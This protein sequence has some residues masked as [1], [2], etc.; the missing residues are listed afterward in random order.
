MID[1]PSTEMISARVDEIVVEGRH[2]VDLGDLS[3]LASSIDELGLL[4]PITVTPDLRLIAGHRRLEACR[5]LDRPII[6]ACVV[7]DLDT[8]QLRLMAERDENV[9]RME[10]RPSEAAS[11]GLALEE[12][13]RPKAAGRKGAR[14]DLQP[15]ANF[16]PG[17]D[18][19]KVND[20]VGPAVG[21]SHETYRKAKNVLRAGRDGEDVDGSPLPE[22]VAKAARDA[23]AQM[24]ATGKVSPAYEKLAAAKAEQSRKSDPPS[25]NSRQAVAEKAERA[26]QLAASGHTSRQIA[27]DL[28]ITAK[29]VQ[30]L[31]KRHGIDIPADAI[32]GRIRIVDTRRVVSETVLELEA[33][34]MSLAVLPNELA[35][36]EVDQ[37]EIKDWVTSLSKSLKALNTFKKQL[38]KEMTQ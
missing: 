33:A 15:G 20:I 38:T 23:L 22:P 12:L 1:R 17:S 29:G 10:M 2:R 11:L 24:D 21:M 30:G 19:G 35:L 14:T 28:N 34:A 6:R 3:S 25:G 18:C 5:M 8:A 31:C 32:V 4:N 13:E 37:S 7:R 16:A 27:A 26:R 36:D 9:C